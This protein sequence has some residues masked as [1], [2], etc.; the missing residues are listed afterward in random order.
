MKN[1]K[2]RY[3][4][5]IALRFL[6]KGKG[7]TLLIVMG[8]AVGVAVQFF[9]SSL[10]GGLQISLIDNTVGSAPHINIFPADRMAK[11]ISSSS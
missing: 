11:P 7:Q 10:I 8:I 9:L 1:R 2:N 4:W 6:M 3:E 5:M